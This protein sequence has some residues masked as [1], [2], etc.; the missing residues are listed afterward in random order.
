MMLAPIGGIGLCDPDILLGLS[1]GIPVLWLAS[2]KPTVPNPL[3]AL[4]LLDFMARDKADF[5]AK[6]LDWMRRRAS[7]GPERQALANRFAASAYT[8]LT[9]FTRRLELAYC[10]MFDVWSSSH[11]E[12]ERLVTMH[13]WRV[14]SRHVLKRMA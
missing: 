13:Q 7:G 12:P 14:P 10:L 5:V 8:N 6:A 4:G 3:A 1:Q 9:A 2:F 11:A